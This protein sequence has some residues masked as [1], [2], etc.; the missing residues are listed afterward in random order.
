MLAI[1]NHLRYNV[2][3]YVPWILYS[4]LTQWSSFA[5]WDA[6]T[7]LLWIKKNTQNLLDYPTVFALDL[8]WKKFDIK[9]WVN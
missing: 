6:S 2:N 9:S 8:I 3:S 5:V 1:F 4:K 7:T